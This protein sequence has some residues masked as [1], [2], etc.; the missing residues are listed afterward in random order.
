MRIRERIKR[1]YGD[2]EDDEMESAR[3]RSVE[4]DDE[5]S[6]YQDDEAGGGFVPGEAHDAAEEREVTRAQL[7]SATAKQVAALL[8]PE[9]VYAEIVVVESPHEPPRQVAA[10]MGPLAEPEERGEQEAGGFVVDD[11]ELEE[12]GGFFADNEDHDGGGFMLEEDDTATSPPPPQPNHRAPPLTELFSKP[13]ASNNNVAGGFLPNEPAPVQEL[14]NKSAEA[15]TSRA[16][17]LT[18]LLSRPP[19]SISNDSGGGFLPRSSHGT[20]QTTTANT[21]CSP[22]EKVHITDQTRN[23]TAKAQEEDGGVD[24]D[25]SMLSHDPDEDEAE[26]EWLVDSLS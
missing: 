13:P 18:A 9:P 20:T 23:D 8:P 12:P 22:D 5:D 10:H 25:V 11:E 24:S 3:E 7:P 15:Q 21:Q 4:D 19:P 1:D 26:P 14:Q 6:A 2:K 17:P 16:P